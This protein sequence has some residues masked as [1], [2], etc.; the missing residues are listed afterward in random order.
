MYCGD[1]TGV[2]EAGGGVG[3]AAVSAASL[4]ALTPS[5]HSSHKA[6]KPTKE[7]GNREGDSQIRCTRGRGGP[8]SARVPRAGFGVPPKRTLSFVRYNPCQPRTT[9]TVEC[10]GNKAGCRAPKAGGRAP[11][12]GGRAPKAGGRDIQAEDHGLQVGQGDHEAGQRP[13][14]SKSVGLI[15]NLAFQGNA[16]GM[17]R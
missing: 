4:S 5:R 11:K 9:P 6:T 12:A 10:Q 14:T 8:G 13:S 1:G 2:V 17:Q 16:L 15:Q 3:E 7:E